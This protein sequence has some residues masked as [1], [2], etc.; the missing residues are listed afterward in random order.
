MGVTD[1]GKTL[2]ANYA[3]V[4]G[5]NGVH[6]FTGGVT[7]TKAVA[8]GG[9]SITAKD[10]VT[11]T[12][13]GTESG[14]TVTAGTA[15]HM[16]VTLPG[17]TFIAGT[18]ASGT[19]S[20][21]KAGTPFTIVSLTAVDNFDN[22]DTTYSGP[23]TI[24]YSGPANSP[25]GS[26][27]VYTTS[28]SFTSGQSTTTLTT[29]LNDAQ[30]TTITATQGSV[31]GIASSS[32]T[33][34]PTTANAYRITAASMTPSPGVGDQLTIKLVDQ[35]GNTETGTSG[36][37]T[38]TFSGLSI[39]GDGTKHPSVTDKSG[40]VV[41][42][43]TPEL[44]TFTAGVSTA[45]GLLVAYKAETQTLNVIDSA[46]LSSTSTGG[47]GVSLTIP[48]VAPVARAYSISRGLNT[49]LRIAMTDLVSAGT[50]SDANFDSLTFT[51]VTTPSGHGATVQNNASFVLYSLAPGSN[52]AS[53]TFNYIISDGSLTATGTV[54][55]TITAD[56]GAQ[57][58]NFV[59]YG[60]QPITL[61]PTMTFAGV[62]GFNYAIQSA[63]MVTGHWTTQTT[64]TAD[65]TTG[66][67]SFT[68]TSVAVPPTTVYYRAINQ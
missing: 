11:G 50:V 60:I 64:L 43:G 7:L 6:T 30:T 42:L 31:T 2:P 67:I 32:I 24:T 33:V 48:N 61:H 13:T 3:F 40:A 54:T 8:S 15:T 36:D 52:P 26:A 65:A 38:L 68:D 55:V 4:A 5:D 18:G 9:Q 28:V 16:I 19:V 66:L 21:E 62:Q 14:I 63:A 47:A 37:E 17:Q 23:Q 1:S 57:T 10:T 45:G 34:S 41:N 27:P 44:I 49:Q 25:S 39:S 12:I 53:D 20:A 29:T 46:S 58:L 35:F 59:S 51:G 56:T 22:I